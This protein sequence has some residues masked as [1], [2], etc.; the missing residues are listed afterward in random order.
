MG[1]SKMVFKCSHSH[2]YVFFNLSNS[3]SPVEQQGGSSTQPEHQ[4]KQPGSED[5]EPQKRPREKQPGSEDQEPQKGPREKQPVS[6]DQ[7]P[8]K[9][10]RE[11]QPGSE[12]QEKQPQKKQR[13]MGRYKVGQMDVFGICY[14]I[15]DCN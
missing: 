2:V 14:R 15:C 5:Q 8:Q 12:D 3:G 6:E 11:K 9:R 4:E 7:E 1:K 13:M 10:P